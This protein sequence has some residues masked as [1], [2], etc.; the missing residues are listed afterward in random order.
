MSDILRQLLNT[1]ILKTPRLIMMLIVLSEKSV[2]FGA[3][4]V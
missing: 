3:A 4:R 2:Q 1:T